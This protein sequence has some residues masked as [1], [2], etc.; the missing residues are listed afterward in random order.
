MVTKSV[1]NAKNGNTV[2]LYNLGKE[3]K[4]KEKI[5]KKIVEK[6]NKVYENYYNFLTVT[7]TAKLHFELH[8]V[9]CTLIF[10]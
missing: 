9:V 10:H 2:N 1:E 6:N 8:N 4:G 5:S 3:K 7:I